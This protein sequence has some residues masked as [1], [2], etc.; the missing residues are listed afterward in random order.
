VRP[1]RHLQ[2]RDCANIEVFVSSTDTD[3]IHVPEWSVN[4]SI[5][6]C[7]GGPGYV[8]SI[9]CHY[10]LHFQQTVCLTAHKAG[11]EN[12]IHLLFDLE[13]LFD[14]HCITFSTHGTIQLWFSVTVN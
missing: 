2:Y 13:E 11:L 12:L 5:P 6:A 10:L 3:D 8:D 7:S 1:P 4:A 14:L 9:S